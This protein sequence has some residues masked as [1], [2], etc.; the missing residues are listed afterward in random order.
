MQ[1]DYRDMVEDLFDECD[2]GEGEHFRDDGA[3]LCVKALGWYY[4]TEV[5]P[6]DIPHALRW[7]RLNS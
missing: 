7:G 4:E 2:V 1:R 5:C 6:V 3:Y